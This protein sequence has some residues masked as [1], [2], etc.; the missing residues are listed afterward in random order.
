MH[1]TYANKKRK[2]F[3]KENQEEYLK[4][5]YINNYDGKS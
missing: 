1:S 2:Q 5:I 3:E 4:L